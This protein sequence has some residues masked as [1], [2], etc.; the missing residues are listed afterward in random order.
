LE[1]ASFLCQSSRFPP[2]RNRE[3]HTFFVLICAWY[4]TLFLVQVKL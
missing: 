4:V 3:I 1:A 2:Q